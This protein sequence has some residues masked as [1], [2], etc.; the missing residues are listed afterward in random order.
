M[1]SRSLPY[2]TVQL[3]FGG[4][5]TLLIIPTGG[6]FVLIRGVWRVMDRILEFIEK[7]EKK[8]TEERE[9]DEKYVQEIN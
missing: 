1:K 6:M 7:K 3:L 8:N 2:N 5:I 4:I 9:D